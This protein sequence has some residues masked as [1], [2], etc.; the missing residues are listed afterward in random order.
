VGSFSGW[1]KGNEWWSGP[2]DN[3][4]MQCCTGNC[5]RALWFLWSHILDFKDGQLKVNMLL[6]RASPW[7]DV[8][9]F[10]PYQGLVEIKVR[11]PCR[12]VLVHAPEWIPTGS[13]EIAVQVGG[14]P[15]A[16]NWQDRYL[17]LGEVKAGD[18]IAIR[19]PISEGAVKEKMGQITYRLLVRG[20]T[21]VSIDPPGRLC[22]LFQREH[23]RT[24]EPRW[25]KVQR[26]VADKQIDY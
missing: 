26:F 15:R 12:D 16:V 17:K 2:Q 9:S 13:K 4:L 14:K 21:V 10:I 20:N 6:N 24:S 19:C 11:Q 18:L 25:R 8:H 3:L 7:A 5:A 1:A 23:L 22:P